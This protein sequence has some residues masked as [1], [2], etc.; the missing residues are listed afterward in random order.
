[1]AFGVLTSHSKSSL[2]DVGRPDLRLWQIHRYRHRNASA[3]CT[4]V[5]YSGRLF[6]KHRLY[7]HLRLRARYQHIGGDGEF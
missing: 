3:S 5:R 1:M 7:Q 6:G 2:A 4:D